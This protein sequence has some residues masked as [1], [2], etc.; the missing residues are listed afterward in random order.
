MFG[1]G[2]VGLRD[3]SMGPSCPAV[4]IGF[5]PETADIFENPIDPL[6]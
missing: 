6:V 4:A 1:G 3:K 5:V 2:G